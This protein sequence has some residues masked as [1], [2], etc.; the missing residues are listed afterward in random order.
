[1]G[2]ILLLLIDGLPLS[3]VVDTE[4]ECMRLGV[5]VVQQAIA[6]KHTA[7]GVCLKSFRI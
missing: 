3:A 7:Q 1:M 2:W 6:A 5:A 4:A